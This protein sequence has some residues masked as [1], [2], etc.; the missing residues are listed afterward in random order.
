MTKKKLTVEELEA[1]KSKLEAQLEGIEEELERVRFEGKES[2]FNKIAV[3]YKDILLDARRYY[4][5]EQRMD[6][7]IT[8]NKFKE[9]M[10]CEDCCECYDT[11]IEDKECPFAPICAWRDGDNESASAILE[12]WFE[13]VLD[14]YIK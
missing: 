2:N 10:P 7:I 5:A 13:G 11:A 14:K 12:D 3:K 6:E 8:E 4:E 1:K 9:G